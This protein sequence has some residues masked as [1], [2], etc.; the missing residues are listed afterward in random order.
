MQGWP[1]FQALQSRSRKEIRSKISILLDLAQQRREEGGACIQ[2]VPRA[3]WIVLWDVFKRNESGQRESFAQTK[4]LAS[5]D[6]NFRTEWFHSKVN[7]QRVYIY[8]FPKYFPPN[9]FIIFTVCTRCVPKNIRKFEQSF[10]RHRFFVNEVLL[11]KKY[12]NDILALATTEH[13][14]RTSSNNTSK[15]VPRYYVIFESGRSIF[16]DIIEIFKDFFWINLKKISITI[17]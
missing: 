8:K 4:I 16:I 9:E 3:T 17:F 1:H 15:K 2:N 12:R 13:K 7:E 5:T 6:F 11:T 10:T 14:V